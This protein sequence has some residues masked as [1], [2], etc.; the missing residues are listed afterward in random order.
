MKAVILAAGY[1][2]RLYPLTRDRPKAL[3]EVGGR[4]ILDHLVT[5]L[6]EISAVAGVV[7]VTN[8][9]FTGQ[10]EAWRAQRSGGKPVIVLDD[11]THSN[12]TRLGALGDLHLAIQKTTPDDDLLVAAA[13]NLLGFRLADLVASFESRRVAHLCVHRV[14]DLARLRRTGVVV[15][16]EDDRVREFAEKPTEPRSHWAAPPLYVFPRG[17]G[18]R[19]DRYLAEGGSPDAPGHFIAWLCQREPVQ[20]FRTVG[21]VL[22]VGTPA[23]LAAARR[24]FASP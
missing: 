24:S 14:D 9:R 10:F 21:P 23:S 6:D 11:G 15:L 18:T 20:A 12:E 19:L 8:Q 4:T 16:D 17:S 13:D 22:D 7:L 1:A 3:L 5:Q 2:T